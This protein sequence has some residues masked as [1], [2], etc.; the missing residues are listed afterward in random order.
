MGMV[1]H[2]GDM[3]IFAVRDFTFRETFSSV[4]GVVC[5]FKG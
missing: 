5:N 4:E 2:E 1:S 3:K